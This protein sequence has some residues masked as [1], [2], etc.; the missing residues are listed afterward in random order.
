MLFGFWRSVMPLSALAGAPLVGL[1]GGPIP[2]LVV[3]DGVP[4]VLAARGPALLLLPLQAQQ[5]QSTA[6]LLHRHL[7]IFPPATAPC[8][9]RRRSASAGTASGVASDRGSSSPRSA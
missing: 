8:G 3:G 5:V 9:R 1:A 6:D 7:R 2:S 4:P